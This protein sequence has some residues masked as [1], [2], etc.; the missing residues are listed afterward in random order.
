MVTK[1]N[2]EEY[3]LLYADGEL[4][5]Q[6]EKELLAFIAQHPELQKELDAYKAAR[7]SPDTDVVFK[8]KQKLLRPTVDIAAPTVDKLKPTV[9]RKTIPFDRRWLYAAAACIAGILVFVAIDRNGNEP[10]N[11]MAKVTEQPQ[12]EIKDTPATLQ[13]TPANPV[14]FVKEPV[15]QERLI[16]TPGRKTPVVAAPK[17][18][19]VYQKQVPEA[20]QPILPQ[21]KKEEKIPEQVVADKKE[22]IP[23][24]PEPVTPQAQEKTVFVVLK[25]DKLQELHEIK[26]VLTEKLAKVKTMA[27]NIRNTDIAFKLGN[28]ELFVVKL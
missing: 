24:I 25:E 2:Y 27:D 20:K 22:V 9:D 23:P 5:G 3:L 19:I 12:P 14:A 4:G 1:E 11:P 18:T 15:K 21:E 13:S 16:K 7:L 17:E 10:V 28:K 6:E 8:D 26:E